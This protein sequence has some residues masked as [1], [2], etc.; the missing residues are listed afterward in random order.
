M[1]RA[2]SAYGLPLAAG[3]ALSLGQEPVALP[4]T[5]LPALVLFALLSQGLDPRAAAGRAWL[6]GFGYFGLTL[7]WIVNPFYVEADLYS[8]M[9]P[10]AAVLLP[11]G[12]AAFWAVGVWIAFRIGRGMGAWALGLII[13]E[14]ARAHLFTGF[15]W[16]QFGQGY[17][18]TISSP[19]MSY[20]GAEGLSVLTIV[21]AA[22]AAA[23]MRYRWAIVPVCAAL[24]LP[25]F[26][27]SPERQIS[28]GPVVRLVQPSAPQDEKWIPERA[29]AFYRRMIAATEAEPPV[30]LVVWPETAIPYLLNYSGPILT[31]IADA[32][33]DTPVIFG[34]N[35]EEG[36]LYYNS[37]AMVGAGGAVDAIYDKRHLVP[38]GE[39]IPI[40]DLLARF[41]IHGLAAADGAAYAE[42]QSGELIT[43]P[44]VGGIVPLICYEGIFPSMSAS[45]E[46][47]RAL[48]LITNDAWFGPD[49]GPR[50]HFAQARLRAIEQGLPMVRVGNTGLTAMIDARG[51]VTASL[52]FERV[53]H[54]DALLPE[55]HEE[56]FFARFGSWPFVIVILLSCSAVGIRRR[57][58]SG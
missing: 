8:W 1:N 38:F 52:P 35:R 23:T 30:D 21:L 31:D 3:M 10:F 11:A 56:T 43:V 24:M 9:A 58:I 18:D 41:G 32:S 57:L 15:P 22:V 44:E 50:Q 4:V 17:L 39:Y 2:L 14:L 40:G 28:D 12:L 37:L 29:E 46:R 36:G 33:N 53:G 19:L 42:G 45:A 25:A 7:T 26:P 5:I 13:A 27:Y 16:V 48:V 49:A 55:A 34:V 6:V 54:V 47:P 51:A 20:I